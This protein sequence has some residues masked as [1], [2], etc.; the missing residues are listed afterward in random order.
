MIGVGC[1]RLIEPSFTHCTY[2]LRIR[3]RE[4]RRRADNCIYAAM[5]TEGRCAFVVHPFLNVFDCERVLTEEAATNLATRQLSLVIGGM[6]MSR[7]KCL[8]RKTH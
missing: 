4:T 1:G 3:D 7:V 8:I 2:E 6:A 5:R